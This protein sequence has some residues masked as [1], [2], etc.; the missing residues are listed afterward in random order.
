M[1]FSG[2]EYWSGLLCLSPGDLPTQRLNLCLLSILHWQFF[3]F[4]FKLSQL[5]RPLWNWKSCQKHLG[6]SCTWVQNQCS[7]KSTW[8][9]KLPFFWAGTGGRREL[10]FFF[11]K[12][13]SLTK[14]SFESL[15]TNTTIHLFYNEAENDNIQCALLNPSSPEWQLRN[16]PF[17]RGWFWHKGNK[18]VHI[19]GNILSN[20]L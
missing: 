14:T 16:A 5:G 7:F 12:S 4:F 18:D 1:G 11:F 6:G 20:H 10:L 19:Q 9:Y 13:S 8:T 3:V 15:K 17:I 2:Q